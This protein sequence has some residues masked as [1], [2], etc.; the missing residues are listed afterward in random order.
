MIGPFL[1]PWTSKVTSAIVQS[2]MVSFITLR[3]VIAWPAYR[4]GIN[5][6]RFLSIIWGPEED[7]LIRLWSD[8]IYG[9]V[10]V[11]VMFADAKIWKRSQIA[12]GFAFMAVPT[13][14]FAF[15]LLVIGLE[16][17]R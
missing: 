8:G 17:N 2:Y 11:Q 14:V 1:P 9:R 4:N 10:P 7:R 5:A 16:G 12:R 3:P 15:F 13:L 6:L